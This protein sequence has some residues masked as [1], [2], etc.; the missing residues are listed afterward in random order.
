LPFRRFLWTTRKKPVMIVVAIAC[1]ALAAGITYW[2]QF[3][4][5]ASAQA[6]PVVLKCMN[7]DCGYVKETNSEQ[8]WEGTEQINLESAAESGPLTF[9]CPQCG[10]KSM[11]TAVKCPKCGEVFVPNVRDLK[12]FPDR[13]PKCR[14]SAAEEETKRQ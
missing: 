8:M 7:K 11:M 4:G 9:M 2:T 3:R 1:I 13:C 6:R 12:D 10:K 5:G 14:Y